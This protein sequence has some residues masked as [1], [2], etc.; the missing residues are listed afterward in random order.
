MKYL[1]IIF[2]VIFN[3]TCWSSS[4]NVS[5]EKKPINE[6][7]LDFTKN[8]ALTIHAIRED[9]KNP[10]TFLP[11]AINHVAD[12][13]L[14]LLDLGLDKILKDFRKVSAN[15]KTRPEEY[16]EFCLRYVGDLS[17]WSGFFASQS[18][19]LTVLESGLSEMS[20][21]LRSP[22]SLIEIY[23][24]LLAF[25][26]QLNILIQDDEDT[27]SRHGHLPFGLL[28][29]QDLSEE[30]NAMMGCIYPELDKYSQSLLM[31]LQ[32]SPSCMSSR[33]GS[34]RR[35]H[36]RRSKHSLSHLE[37]VGFGS[38]KGASDKV[39]I[40]PVLAGVETIIPSESLIEC[41]LV[42]ALQYD[43]IREHLT[44]Q[45]KNIF[46][47][48][49]KGVEVEYAMDEKQYYLVHPGTGLRF[50]LGYFRPDTEL[51]L[52]TQF[53]KTKEKI[54]KRTPKKEVEP[55]TEAELEEFAEG[56]EKSKK[57]RKKGR[58]DRGAG[59]GPSVKSEG[60][61]SAPKPS[62]SSSPSQSSMED[63][64]AI[65][66]KLGF[67][68]KTR[69]E[70]GDSRKGDLRPTEEEGEREEKDH[71][72][73]GGGAL[74]SYSV[75][76]SEGESIQSRVRSQFL[77]IIDKDPDVRGF[78]YTCM[79]RPYG[80]N[81]VKWGEGRGYLEKLASEL[82]GKLTSSGKAS[83]ALYTKDNYKL[84]QVHGSHSEGQT[85]Y[86]AQ[87]NIITA[88]LLNSLGLDAEALLSVLA[89]E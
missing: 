13:P 17:I 86:S 54:I 29:E 70:S 23:N 75:D 79:Y 16:E 22:K 35:L 84:L 42:S 34:L 10:C 62:V 21:L 19:M 74:S 8:L 57:R 49:S 47:V 78:L 88:W 50:F 25:A 65:L 9:L 24:V 26:D 51:I 7:I 71:K 6:H 69:Q 66:R 1:F 11:S 31:S 37:I 81:Q 43:S 85:M 33:A 14:E 64:L 83:C 39:I 32:R 18:N 82:K 52:R 53:E 48:G 60:A 87:G 2:V 73:G 44:S 36:D 56:D 41:E 67:G 89:K 77:S 59:S 28:V 3:N 63:S 30:L 12:S 72:A 15:S 55:F 58:G 68:P 61:E 76:E 4:G 5:E 20:E 27:K 80:L 45:G 40:K 46:R 38:V